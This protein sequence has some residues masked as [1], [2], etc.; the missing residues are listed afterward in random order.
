MTHDGRT[1]PP[2]PTS[3]P[4]SVRTDRGVTVPARGS[5][6]RAPRSERWP[7][8]A[9]AGRTPVE[10]HASVADAGIWTVREV[11]VEN[12]RARICERRRHD[13]G[14]ARRSMRALQ[15]RAPTTIRPAAV[16]PL[17]TPRVAACSHS[18]VV[19]RSATALRERRQTG[20]RFAWSSAVENPARKARVRE[21]VMRRRTARLPP[22]PRR[23][24]H[25]GPATSSSFS[26]AFAALVTRRRASHFP[27]VLPRC[28]A[29]AG[30][31]TRSGSV[32]A[33]RWPAG[34]ACA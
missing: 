8:L 11:K 34:G 17:T 1:S 30:R 31:V 7:V 20:V 21:P 27:P 25:A 10:A 13:D 5:V 32:R 33:G 3:P 28:R 16:D 18:P 14:T 24:A 15:A 6:G 12:Q 9:V 19:A 29:W 22:R 4:V 23:D 2:V 26:D